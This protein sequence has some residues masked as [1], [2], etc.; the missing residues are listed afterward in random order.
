MSDKSKNFSY[1][2]LT[3]D[4]IEDAT[5]TI[6]TPDTDYPAT[7]LQTIPM[8]TTA[9]A[10]DPGGGEVIRIDFGENVNPKFWSLLNTDIT[11]GNPLITSYTDAWITAEDTLTMIYRALDMKAYKNGGWTPRRYFDINF[12][13]CAFSQAFLEVGKL[14]AALD[15]TV[16]T[17]NFSPGISRGQGNR[18]IHNITPAGIEYTHLLQEK[19]NYLGVSWDPDL[20]DPVLTEILAFIQATKGGGYPAIIIPNR[21]EAELF[22][23]RNQDR[24]NWDEMAARSLISRCSL[25]F[26]ELS[27]GKIQEG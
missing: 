19:I 13:A 8:G 15:M 3:D 21:E 5:V 6:L 12:N 23:M 26:K 4:L 24:T 2:P 18:N 17:H 27:R 25:N 7:E 14:I 11:S 16:F 9:R 20:K 10:T 1:V 22:Y